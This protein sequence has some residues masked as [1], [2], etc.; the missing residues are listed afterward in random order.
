MRKVMIVL[1]IM[2]TILFSGCRFL[3]PESKEVF[4][5]TTGEEVQSDELGES[6]TGKQE[7]DKNTGKESDRNDD[8]ER[9]PN[10]YIDDIDEQQERYTTCYY[11]DSDGLLIP[12][13]R[14]TARIEGIAKAAVSA[15]VDMPVIRE[16]IIKAG[17]FPVLPKGTR[18]LGM[19]IR[20]GAAIVD[21]NEAILNYDNKQDEKNLL[22][23]LVYTL[24]EFDTIESVEIMKTG[25]KLTSLKYGSNLSSPL[26]RGGINQ[27][28]IYEEKPE[29]DREWVEV[30][31]AKMVYNKYTYYVPVGRMIN[32]P[33]SD[34]DRYMKMLNE[35][36]KGVEEG[37]G[38]KSFIPE[39]TTIRGIR[40]D[41][42][43]VILD[44]DDE[45]LNAAHSNDDFS[46]MLKQITLCF[47]QFGKI[48]SVEMNVNGKPLEYMGEYKGKTA[49]EVPLYANQYD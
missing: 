2:C 35:L 31:F 13:T 29:K 19:T 14:K 36:L 9:N 20:D 27:P 38:L 7:D 26:V 48:K 18:V 43:T 41:G 37:K 24:T 21:F 40:I 39:K 49:L 15:L 44:F 8:P 17:L 33:S 46:K 1:M 10:T 32:T 11:Q 22:T 3:E 23:S 34:I 4:K 25:E 42:Q 12:I 5:E 6:M 30:Y 45:L 47:K 28:T 16:D